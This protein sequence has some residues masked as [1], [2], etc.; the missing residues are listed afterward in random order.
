M[1]LTPRLRSHIADPSTVETDMSSEPNVSYISRKRHHSVTYDGFPG[2]PPLPK[3][4]GMPVLAVFTHKSLRLACHATY[5]DN[6]RLTILGQHVLDM[7]TTHLLFSRKPKLKNENIEV[8]RR[9][10]LS[11]QVIDFWSRLYR[12][13]DELRYDP[14][15]RSSVDEPEHGRTLFLAYLAAAFEEH[16]LPDVQKWIRMLFQVTAN[17]MDEFPAIDFGYDASEEQAGKRMKVEGAPQGPFSFSPNFAPLGKS[18]V[19]IPM[20]SIYNPYS[21]QPAPPSSAPPPIPPPP[22]P[23]I[24]SMPP[25]PPNPL[26][27][28]Q[29][30]LAFLPLFN[31]TA[32]QRGMSVEYPATFAGPPHAGRWHVIC[33][34]NGI[35]KGKGTGSSKQLAKEQ[36]ARTAYFAMGW[37]PR[38]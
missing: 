20:K 35:E 31:Q 12:L 6:E 17:V 23:P 36:A 5:D 11:D 27:P 22:P 25:F 7:V 10:L 15:F 38:G 18:S 33:K 16:G 21:S 29:P 14:S 30:S 2:L 32:A 19:D 3:L 24:P 28:A 26:A 4:S 37:A 9:T 8:L 1:V 34:V 13:R